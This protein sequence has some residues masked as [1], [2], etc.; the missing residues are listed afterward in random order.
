MC[1]KIPW[2]CEPHTA[3]KHRVLER[4]LQAWWPIMLNGFPRVTYVE[5][6]AG[7]GIYKGGEPGSPIIALRTLH[8]AAAPDKPVDLIFVDREKRCLT[9]LREQMDTSAP[10]PRPQTKTRLIHGNA[11]DEV[12][13]QIEAVHG[14][15]GG[16]FAFL[17][18]W[19]NVAVPIDVVRRLARRGSEVFVTL[20]S[21]FWTQFGSAVGSDWDD[22]FGS[23]EWRRVSEI[24]GAP[25]KAAFLKTCYRS[26]LKDAGFDFILDFELVD[27][28]GQ[29]F[30]LIHGTT[31]AL[32]FERMKDALW[33]VDP[34]AG[35]GFR[36]PRGQAEGQ[37]ALGLIWQPELAPLRDMILSWVAER[38]ASV[39]SLRDRV[40][41]ETIYKRM[42]ATSVIRD[43]VQDGLLR[44][45]PPMGRLSGTSVVSRP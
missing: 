3:A 20:G 12:L 23:A 1:M 30:Y 15:D 38:P 21:R 28:H 22:M 10:Q 7:P 29:H 31:H 41:G 25:A 4:Y 6:F 14:W 18:S 40:F 42:H 37:Q 16:V 32:G 19:G 17:D 39:D 27:D 11:A 9:M 33:K 43:L 45:D 44:R 24:S 5:G 26:A 35:A 36:D 13:A 8:A 2:D 34:V